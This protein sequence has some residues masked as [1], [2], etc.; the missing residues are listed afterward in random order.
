VALHPANVMRPSRSQYP[1]VIQAAGLSTRMGVLGSKVL[2]PY[3]GRPLLDHIVRTALA[4]R[5]AEVIVVLGHEADRVR[6]V[7]GEDARVRSVVNAEYA[8]GRSTSI[9]AGLAAVGTAA[10]GALFLL[11]DQPHMT[12]DLI[13]AVI[14][15][16]EAEE[17]RGPAGAPLIVA[18]FASVGDV[19]SGGGIDADAAVRANVKGNPVLFRRSLFEKLDALRGDR[20]ALDLIESL[21]DRAAR[22]PIENPATQTRIETPEDY[23][24]LVAGDA[25]GR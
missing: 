1:G 10:P 6:L 21:W 11:G 24:R 3:R 2:L 17:A 5:L 19:A 12:A 4:S 7:L 23:D 15:A 14:G 18:A 25:A 8:L 22:V 16:A 13:D 20:G 9:R